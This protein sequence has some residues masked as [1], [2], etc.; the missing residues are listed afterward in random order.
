MVSS[1]A[2][3][4][5][6][7]G[8]EVAL[9]TGRYRHDDPARTLPRR[10]T[11]RGV[12]VHR[13]ATSHFGRLRLAGRAADYASFHA[14]AALWCL[15]HLRHGDIVVACT[16]PPLLSVT[17]AAACATRGARL[18][19]WL[20]DIFPE[21]AIELGM[22]ARHGR[23][24]RLC[25][26]ARD[27][28]LRRA[29]RNVVPTV[30][31]G[32]GLRKRGIDDRMTT[33]IPYWSEE[34]EIRPIA[35]MDNALRAEWGLEDCFVVG[36]SGNFG[37]AHDF[38]T[39]LDAA[40]NLLGEPRIRFLLIGGGFGRQWLEDEIRRRGL[41]NVVLRPQQ[42]RERLAE[43]LSVADV[44]LVSL[45]PALEP[46]I[47]PSKLYGIMAAGRA[48]LFV[49]ASDGEVA[50]ILR[51]Q[52]IGHTVAIGEGAALAARIVEL[53]RDRNGCEAMGCRAREAFESD[54][55]RSRAVT[56]WLELLGTVETQGH[57]ATTRHIDLF[58]WLGRDR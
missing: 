8:V 18:V 43:S 41:I 44:H 9:V 50:I 39:L 23:L 16:D 42:P 25:L 46:Y 27:W 34:D 53:R 11:I 58:R 45:R 57:H 1:L 40:E 19:N 33:I 47:V 24:A 15:T 14:G 13:I 52:G 37:R 17:L 31:M 32:R 54:H 6:Q 4:L 2:F 21:V 29:V 55:R 48:V 3:G 30:A 5:A 22:I 49:G 20:H 38:A 10:E 35:M 28:S 26:A 7:T 56:D 12:G 51:S 36:Y